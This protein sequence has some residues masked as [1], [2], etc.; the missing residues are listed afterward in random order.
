LID[1]M[2]VN[3]EEEEEDAVL[4]QGGPPCNASVQCLEKEARFMCL[5]RTIG[6]T[7]RTLPGFPSFLFLVSIPTHRPNQW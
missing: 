2:E 3:A 4:P 7:E 1:V 6:A 5:L